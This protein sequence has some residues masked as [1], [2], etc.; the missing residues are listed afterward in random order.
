MNKATIKVL[1][2]SAKEL[3]KACTQNSSVNEDK[4]LKVINT[5]TD[6]GKMEITSIINFI[7]NRYV[8]FEL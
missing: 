6:D 7:N 1:D 8:D 3:I 4:I 2:N 5:L